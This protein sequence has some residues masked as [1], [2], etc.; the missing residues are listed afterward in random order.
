MIKYLLSL[1]RSKKPLQVAAPI[2]EHRTYTET[3]EFIKAEEFEAI[4]VY[5]W[6]KRNYNDH[7]NHLN[8]DEY[9]DYKIWEDLN[10]DIM[11]KKYIPNHYFVRGENPNIIFHGGC[12][13]CLSQR[14]Y[15]FDRCK[16]C[17]YFRGKNHDN[18]S[19]KI[20][21]EEADTMSADELRKLLGE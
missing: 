20:D 21:G 10:D 18:P 11:R 6:V 15:G 4:W 17:K 9:L 12:L 3:G 1:F 19:L 7:P 5:K 8:D 14:L 13:G 16:G 2:I